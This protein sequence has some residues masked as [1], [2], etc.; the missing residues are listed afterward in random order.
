MSQ[1]KQNPT[2]KSHLGYSP[3]TFPCVTHRQMEVNPVKNTGCSLGGDKSSLPLTD[4]IRSY[5]L[6]WT[7]KNLNLKPMSNREKQNQHQNKPKKF[8]PFCIRIVKG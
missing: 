7:G 3:T 4:T 5:T 6:I 1:G 2:V 8:T